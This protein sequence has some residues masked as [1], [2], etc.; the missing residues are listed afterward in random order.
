MKYLI[1]ILALFIAPQA[2][3]FSG[4]TTTAD[5][6]RLESNP[7]NYDRAE[8]VVKLGE[9]GEAI[10]KVDEGIESFLVSVVSKID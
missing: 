10:V 1:L 2:Q 8:T 4:I 5:W 7:Y 9:L 6:M 3:A